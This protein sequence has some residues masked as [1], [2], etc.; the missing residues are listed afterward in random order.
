MKRSR[1]EKQ[2]DVRR[3]RGLVCVYEAAAILGKSRQTLY[4]WEDAGRMPERITKGSGT[5]T[6]YRRADILVL[7]ATRQVP[8][9]DSK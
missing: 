9:T 1:K 6:Y 4:R 2:V 5:R 7:A 3:I 8:G